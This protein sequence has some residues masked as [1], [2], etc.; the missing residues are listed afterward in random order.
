MDCNI[1]GNVCMYSKSCCVI[2]LQ[3]IYTIIEEFSVENK[4]SNCF[5]SSVQ[6]LGIIVTGI[7][8]YG[9]YNYIDQLHLEKFDLIHLTERPDFF[10]QVC[11]INLAKKIKI[12]HKTKN[13]NLQINQSFNID[14]E[15]ILSTALDVYNYIMIKKYLNDKKIS[16]IQNTY[17][18]ISNVENIS[19]IPNNIDYSKLVVNYHVKPII[20]DLF[21]KYFDY[22]N[23]KSDINGF[24]KDFDT[25]LF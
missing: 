21:Y 8:L 6:L 4:F 22:K 16:F 13:T 24:I 2:N 19:I 5:I 7:N 10:E 11:S 20:N 23:M 15:V 1:Y 17:D 25:V 9:I 12:Y 14:K 18:T 3:S